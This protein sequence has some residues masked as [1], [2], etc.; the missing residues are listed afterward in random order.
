MGFL[1]M[2]GVLVILLGH[3]G[4]GFGSLYVWGGVG[5]SDTSD[6]T[7]GLALRLVFGRMFGVGRVLLKMHILVF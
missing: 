5:S 6:L 2:G 7:Q 3:M 4:W 1:G